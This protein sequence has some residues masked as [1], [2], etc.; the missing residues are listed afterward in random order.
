[1]TRLRSL[2][3]GLR[4]ATSLTQLVLDGN[5]DLERIPELPAVKD[6]F[7]TNCSSLKHVGN[8]LNDEQLVTNKSLTAGKCVVGG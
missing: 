8:D 3:E 5:K 4:H 2:P 7:V 6:L 1:M